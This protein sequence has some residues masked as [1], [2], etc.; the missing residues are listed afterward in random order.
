MDV[1]LEALYISEI[2]LTE[3]PN[4]VLLKWAALFSLNWS[5]RT[6]GSNAGVRS[7][8]FIQAPSRYQAGKPFV[9]RPV[10][11]FGFCIIYA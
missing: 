3:N 8:F 7:C 1:S 9:Y 6:L 11:P 5:E 2:S 10:K 4:K